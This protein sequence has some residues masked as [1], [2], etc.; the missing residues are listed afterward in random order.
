MFHVKR[1]CVGVSRETAALSRPVDELRSILWISPLRGP[2]GP[3]ENAVRAADP[4]A[5]TRRRHWGPARPQLTLSLDR[6]RSR[7]PARR[8]GVRAR[9]PT[10]PG[11]VGPRHPHHRGGGIEQPAPS[12][13]HLRRTHSATGAGAPRL[14]DLLVRPSAPFMA[15]IAPV[16]ATS[17][18]DQPSRR[19]SGATARDVTTSNVAVPCSVLGPPAD[20]RHVAELQ[21]G[22]DLVEERRTSQQRLDQRHREVRSGDRQDQP[23]Q[24]G[25]ASRCR[26]PRSPPAQRRRAPRS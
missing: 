9:R 10:Y 2:S 13:M 25:A 21:L 20:D 22:H 17:G 3:V 24:T 11:R 6:R 26:T 5:P 1:R 16:G 18:I 7:R 12:S 14:R 19:S 15:T 8:S 4:A 23:G